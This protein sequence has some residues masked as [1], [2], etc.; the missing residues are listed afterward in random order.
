M[1]QTKAAF[2]QINGNVV[3]VLDY[4]AVGDG[5]TD[6][7]GAFNLLTAYLATLSQPTDV[8]IPA[9]T[10]KVNPKNTTTAIGS[11]NACLINLPNNGSR[12][13]GPGLIQIDNSVDYTSGFSVG[14]E[15]YWSVVLISAD[16]CKVEGLRFDGNG[17]HTATGYNPGVVNIR[18]QMVGSFGTAL[19]HRAGNQVTRCQGVDFGGQA[20]AFQYQDGAIISFNRFNNH[21]GLGVSVG[22]DAKIICNSSRTC[23]DAPIYLNPV[24]GGKVIGNYSNGTSNG[25]GC[26]IVGCNDV[27][28]CNNHFRGSFGAG[29]WVHYSSQQSV[30]SK[31]IH[32]HH[33]TLYANARYTST[34]VVGEIKIGRDSNTPDSANDVTV[35]DNNIYMDGSLG[36]TASRPFVTAYGVNDLKIRRNRI[37]GIANSSN[38]ISLFEHDIAGLEFIDNEWVGSTTTQNLSFGSGI[39]ATGVTIKDNIGIINPTSTNIEQNTG[40]V[41][42]GALCFEIHKN[43]GTSATTIADITFNSGAIE[44][45][46]VEVTAVQIGEFRG[47]AKNQIVLR[48]SSAITPTTVS[49]ATEVA[50]GNNPPVVSLSNSTG[51]SQIQIASVGSAA[52]TSIFIKVF[53]YLDNFTITF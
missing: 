27:E 51:R 41:R 39:T 50:Q 12:V 40:K 4:G 7:T 11:S 33:N 16:D 3:S 23:Y 9:G 5:V 52:D 29:I 35:E 31:R 21:S 2:N 14:D 45:C 25:S 6:D 34:P 28:I 43:I 32:I 18:F 19:S 36:A 1:T 47:V 53:A 20:V 49:N 46:Y 42:D 48:S 24:D 37:Y 26:D 8:Y 13:Y 15:E 22:S 38:V 17:K 44:H 30:G 10:Y